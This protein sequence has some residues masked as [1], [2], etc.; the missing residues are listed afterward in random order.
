MK[1]INKAVDMVVL[2]DKNGV[3]PI[4]FKIINEDEEEQVV[5]IKRVISK[6]KQKIAGVSYIIFNCVVELNEYEKNCEIR[7][8]VMDMIWYVYKI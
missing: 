1:A 2:F 7:F 8:N 4:R 6:E 5:K 3:K